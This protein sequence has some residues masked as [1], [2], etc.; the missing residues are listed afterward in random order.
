ME[1]LT[2]NTLIQNLYA[3]RHT[4][5]VPKSVEL[6]QNA[7][8]TTFYPSLSGSELNDDT[9]IEASANFCVV[10]AFQ[11]YPGL[12]NPINSVGLKYS[13]EDGVKSFSVFVSN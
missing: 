2:R 5:E 6:V 7:N 10:T 4:G 3:W 11:K 13:L 9:D 12:R 1:T 8:T